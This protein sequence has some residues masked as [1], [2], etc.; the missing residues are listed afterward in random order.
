MSTFWDGPAAGVSLM[1]RRTPLVLRL[2]QDAANDWDVLEQ[3]TD[4]PDPGDKLYVY[5]RAST[6]AQVHLCIGGWF[7]F[8]DYRIAPEQPRDDQ[9]RETPAWNEWCE[10]NR[11][12]ILEWCAPVIGDSKVVG[13][14]N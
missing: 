7:S 14:T 6:S 12:R 4:K 2:A 13:P 8:A 5:M 9:M 11:T 1:I 3:F 10:A